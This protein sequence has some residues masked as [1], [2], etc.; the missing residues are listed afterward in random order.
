VED[1]TRS[2]P[3]I[4]PQIASS[5]IV[6]VYTDLGSGQDAWWTLPLTL[7]FSG[8]SISI[9]YAFA[10][11]ELSIQILKASPEFYAD[12]IDGFRMRVVLISLGPMSKAPVDHSDYEA[13]AAYY[14]L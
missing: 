3:E 11:G 10:A 4:T 7:P 12:V 1:Y 6:L 9:T 13:V 14:G 8:G 2:V 5:G